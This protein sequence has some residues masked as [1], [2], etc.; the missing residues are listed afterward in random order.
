MPHALGDRAQRLSGLH[1]VDGKRVP[2]VMEPQSWKTRPLRDVAERLLELT[3]DVGRPVVS[4]EQELVGA[5]AGPT[6]G[7]VSLATGDM[8]PD[9]LDGGVVQVDGV[10]GYR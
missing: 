10:P 8:L 7:E 9:Q 5:R 6:F 3:Q 1:E 2:Q 4:G